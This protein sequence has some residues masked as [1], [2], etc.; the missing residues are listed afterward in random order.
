MHRDGGFFLLLGDS[1]P[2]SGRV[3]VV[4]VPRRVSGV[5]FLVLLS[6][7][8]RLSVTQESALSFQYVER[9][10]ISTLHYAEQGTSVQGPQRVYLLSFHIVFWS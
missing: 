1:S 8:T 6:K 9:F 3:C 2:L 4:G 7:L 10:F 5:C